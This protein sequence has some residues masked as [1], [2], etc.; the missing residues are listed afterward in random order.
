MKR[1]LDLHTLSSEAEDSFWV[2]P[3]AA[4]SGGGLLAT[5]WFTLAKLGGGCCVATFWTLSCA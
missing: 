1:F 4:T 2:T 3:D 5:R